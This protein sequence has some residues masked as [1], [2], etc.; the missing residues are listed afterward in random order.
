MTI[1]SLGGSIGLTTGGT[2]IDLIGYRMSKAS[3]NMFSKILGTGGVKFEV[4]E[5]AP[6]VIALHPGW[7][8]VE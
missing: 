5:T 3:V 2:P 7:V 6:I 8:D 1:S 4:G